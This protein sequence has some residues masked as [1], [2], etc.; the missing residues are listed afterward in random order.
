MHPPALLLKLYLRHAVQDVVTAHSRARPF[1]ARSTGAR[2]WDPRRRCGDRARW[3]NPVVRCQTP[4]PQ[5][6]SRRRA[7]TRSRRIRPRGA[8]SPRRSRCWSPPARLLLGRAPDLTTHP[9]PDA[10]EVHES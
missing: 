3:T 4:S 2:G 8:P 7:M 5:P 10:L 1:D 9:I 6:L